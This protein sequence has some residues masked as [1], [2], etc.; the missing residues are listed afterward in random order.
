ME[1]KQE[2]LLPYS[3][4]Q[5]E[6]AVIYEANIRHYS[7]EGTFEVFTNDIHELQKMGVKILWV[8]PVQP[9]S[10]KR[11]KA[12][13]DKLIEDI[14]DPEER[15]K[16]LGSDYAIADYR[17]IDT[18]FGTLED[19]KTLVDCAHKNGMYVILDWVA[20]HTGWD[21]PWLE[22][23]PE[24]YQKDREG[25]ITEPINGYTGEKEGWSDVAQ[26]NYDNEDLFE[27]MTNEM[28][29][30]LKE[31]SID[32]FRC[33][34]AD[35]VKLEFWEY[36][37]ARLNEEKPVFML[38]ESDNPEYMKPVFDMGFNWKIHHILNE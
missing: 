26:L 2:K 28:L 13:G 17:A 25:N 19:F 12:P 15:K 3:P 34:V 33:D 5:A 20:N 14:E 38:M 1:K 35:R 21:H 36:A 32:G 30:W 22:A 11:R 29:Y 7:K 9:V 37:Y 4:A 8:M 23:Y 31:T 24:Y 16:V 18:K 10:L 6:N 27:A